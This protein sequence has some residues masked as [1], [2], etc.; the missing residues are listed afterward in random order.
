MITAPATAADF[1]R[2]EALAKAMSVEALIYTVRDCSR[3][4]AAMEGWNPN[5][6]GYYRDQGATYYQELQ[7][8]RRSR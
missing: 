8:R 5:R 3:A 6:E 4:A 2:W 1:A 7:R